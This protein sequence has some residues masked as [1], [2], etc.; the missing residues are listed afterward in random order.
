MLGNVMTWFD[1]RPGH[2]NSISGGKRILSAI[3]PMLLLR[4]GAPYICTG[5]PGGRRIMSAMLHVVTNLVDWGLPP[6]SAVNAWRTHC[7][8]PDLLIDMRVPQATR[9]ALSA[10]G[11][12][13]VPRVETFASTHFARP[14]AIVVRGAEKRAGVGALKSST[15]IG[16]D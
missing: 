15:A 1:P 10:M 8:G 11:H 2:P 13:V 4:D 7:E 6:Q 5:A 3:A 16:V 9:D 12:H 14:S